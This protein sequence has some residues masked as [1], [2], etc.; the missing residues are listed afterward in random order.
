VRPSI[1]I[2]PMDFMPY[3]DGISPSVKLFNGVVQGYVY[4]FLKLLTLNIHIRN[5]RLPTCI[6]V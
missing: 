3:T 1:I 4:L 2:L 5:I 6:G